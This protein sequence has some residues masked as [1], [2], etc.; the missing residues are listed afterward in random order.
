MAVVALQ[1]DEAQAGLA[2]DLPGQGQR[3]LAR[4][5]AAAVH[6]DVHLDQH[7][8]RRARRPRRLRQRGDVVGVID[9]DA[10]LRA[11]GQVGQAAQL[12]AGRRSGWRRRRR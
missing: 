1:A 8:E 10:D 6:A 3:R 5:D 9:A 4:L 7:A 11:A 12:D 2:R